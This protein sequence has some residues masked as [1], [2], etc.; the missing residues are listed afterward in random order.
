LLSDSAIA[1]GN[2]PL[3]FMPQTLMRTAANYS[4]DNPPT[5][6]ADPPPPGKAYFP[7]G[8]AFVDG[9]MFDNEPLGMA[10]NF[11]A[12]V[13]AGRPDPERLFLLVH[14]NVT[15]GGHRDETDDKIG[16]LSDDFGLA[17]QAKRLLSML[18]TE[19]AVSDWVRANKV[20][21][22]AAWRDEFVRALG[23]MIAGTDVTDP[24]ALIKGSVTSPR[25]SPSRG[26][27]VIPRRTS[28]LRSCRSRGEWRR[29]T[30]D[31]TPAE[32]PRASARRSSS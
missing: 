31:S 18:M 2:F 19:N 23:G 5:L 21:D 29:S 3:A 12:D 14:P 1:S 17:A 32:D 11:A 8:L 15:Q 10:I 4:A 28:R 9:G 20:N 27:K 26:G 24:A 7:H 16:Y 13:D 22:R 25:R 6:A 30:K